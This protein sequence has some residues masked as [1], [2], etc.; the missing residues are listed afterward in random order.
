MATRVALAR[1]AARGADWLLVDEPLSGL[2]PIAAQPVLDTLRGLAD[3]GAGVLWTTHHLGL[4][5]RHADRVLVLADGALRAELRPP[6]PADL[7]AAGLPP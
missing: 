3:R 2:D 4:A 5:A 6:Y 7:L 1:A